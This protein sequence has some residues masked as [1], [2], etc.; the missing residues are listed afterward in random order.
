ML[1]A[2]AKV[3]WSGPSQAVRLPKA[4]RLMA[5]EVTIKKFGHALILGSRSRA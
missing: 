4:F 1:Q 2:K 3:F 5:K